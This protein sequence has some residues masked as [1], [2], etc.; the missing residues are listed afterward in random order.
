MMKKG[1]K[2]KKRKREDL[3]CHDALKKSTLLLFCSLEKGLTVTKGRR[4][5]G[6]EKTEKGKKGEREGGGK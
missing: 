5:K 4:R 2:K 6:R 1:G 3:V